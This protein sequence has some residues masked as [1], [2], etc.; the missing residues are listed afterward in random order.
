MAD[1]NIEN[2]NNENGPTDELIEAI[3]KLEDE[4]D[5]MIEIAD[6]E[7]G[8]K[9]K[10]YVD[11]TFQFNGKTYV[12]LIID[13]DEESED[14]EGEEA[15]S[16]YYIMRFVDKGG[17]VLLENLVGKEEVTIANL[18]SL[19]ESFRDRALGYIQALVDL[20]EE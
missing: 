8:E 10:A 17:E 20:E 19:G 12:V 14:A 6:E 18:R 7:T 13:S 15:D 9:R 11:Q 5:R 1:E 3:A 16:Y 2:I 4:N